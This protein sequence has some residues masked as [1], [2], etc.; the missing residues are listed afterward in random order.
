M[1][2]MAL[3]KNVILRRP[4]SGRLE[5]RKVTIPAQARFIYSLLS[6][7][8]RLRAG[9]KGVAMNQSLA[10]PIA[11]GSGGCW[12][13]HPLRS[14]L[15]VALTPDPF[16]PAI[17]ESEMP[18]RDRSLK[19]G[20]PQYPPNRWNRITSFHRPSRIL[21]ACSPSTAD[22][23]VRFLILT[24]WCVPYLLVCSCHFESH[25]HPPC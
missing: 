5:G 3:G 10:K 15:A 17:R 22:V 21:S 25:S 13:R 19:I 6:G 7:G 12:C 8:R 4:R 1:S 20:K 11:T 16:W 2:L 14:S 23:G 9:P 18:G 24:F